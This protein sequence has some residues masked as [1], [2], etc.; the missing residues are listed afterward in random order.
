[1]G[2]PDLLGVPLNL[3]QSRGRGDDHQR[4]FWSPEGRIMMNWGE[5]ADQ[6]AASSHP[7][8]VV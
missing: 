5:I 3:Q 8:P 6:E 7:E 1:M 4:S 2:V